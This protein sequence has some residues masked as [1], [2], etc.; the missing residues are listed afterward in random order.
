MKLVVAIGASSF[1]V[2]DDTPLRLLIDSGVEVRN[3][4]YGRRLTEEE[5]IQHL[6][7]VDGLLAGLEPLNKNVLSASPELKAIARIG[8]GMTNV[9]IVEAKERGIKVSNTPDGP[10]KAV[11]EMTLTAALA[12]CRKLTVENSLLHQ[13][14][15]EKHISSSLDGAKV[16][17]IGYGRIGRR[18][19]E[20]FQVFGADILVVDPAVK[21]EMLCNNE[22]LVSLEEGLNEAQLISIHASGTDVLLGHREFELMKE[23]VILLNSARGELV[24]ENALVRALD[25]ERVSGAWFDA[26]WEEPYKGVLCRYEQ[27]LLTPHV[28]TYTRECRL[29]MET[30]AVKN[31]LRDLGVR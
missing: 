24:D 27:V 26:F 30:E 28:S 17:I 11:A 7:G 21:P 3:N 22:R 13:G 10:T 8:I 1:A 16:L 18:T 2:E 20:L 31:L 15:W 6:R 12:L 23:G 9:D 19:G 14:R 4:T 29:S 25:E 5:T